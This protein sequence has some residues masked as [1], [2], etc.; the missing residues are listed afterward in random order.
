M[1]RQANPDSVSILR[2]DAIAQTARTGPWYQ[3]GQQHAGQHPG[4]AGLRASMYR[5]LDPFWGWSLL[6]HFMPYEEASGA[7]DIAEI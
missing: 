6:A 7:G 2:D 1:R 5:G 3:Q 4:R